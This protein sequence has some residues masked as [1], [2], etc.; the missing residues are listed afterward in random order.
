MLGHAQVSVRRR[1]WNDTEDEMARKRLRDLTGSDA[2]FAALAEQQQLGAAAAQQAAED[3]GEVDV[4]GNGWAV[5][6]PGSQP[7]E[8]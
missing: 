6:E 7:A 2:D 8:A 5:P 1:P 3:P 4:V